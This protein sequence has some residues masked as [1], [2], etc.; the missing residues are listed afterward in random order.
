MPNSRKIKAR[1]LELGLSIKVIAK[2]MGL[3]AYTLGRKIA[4]KT[5]MSLKEAHM[6]QVILQIPDNELVLYFFMKE[7]A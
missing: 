4:G 1:I 5:P 3:T 7:V 2:Q 6:L